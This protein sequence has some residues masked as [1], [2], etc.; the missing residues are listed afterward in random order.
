MIEQFI[1][2]IGSRKN[3]LTIETVGS[4]IASLIYK[5]N[6]ALIRR[7]INGDD[8]DY[9]VANKNMAAI[10]GLILDEPMNEQNLQRWA[11]A[12]VVNP[13]HPIQRRKPKPIP[14][15]VPTP[16]TN[17]E[18]EFNQE[19]WSLIQ[20]LN[21]HLGGTGDVLSFSLKIKSSNGDS[22]KLKGEAE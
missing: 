8:L 14:V 16:S 7:I 2:V 11:K 3:T 6:R 18:L 9:V 4:Y 22:I 15:V 10:M 21:S 20:T 13:T 19:L 12:L 17:P 1:P 5:G